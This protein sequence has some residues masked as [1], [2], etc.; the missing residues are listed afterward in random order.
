ML[1]MERILVLGI[2]GFLGNRFF[3]YPQTKYNLIGTSRRESSVDDS[4]VIFFEGADFSSLAKILD[5]IKPSIVLNF[6]AITNVDFC[7]Q[8]ADISNV[9]NNLLPSHLAIYTHE[10]GIKLIH[11]STDHFQSEANVPRTEFTNVWSV[12]SYGKSKLDAEVNILEK[13]KNAV[14]IRTNF[15]GLETSHI[16]KKLLSDIKTQLEDESN[17]FGFTDVIFSPVSI[18]TLIPIIYKLIEFDVKGVINISSNESIS[19]FHFAQLVAIGLYISPD[20]VKPKSISSHNLLS[21]RPSYLALDNSKVKQILNLELPSL[22]AMIA[23]ELKRY[24]H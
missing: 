21:K 23:N 22:H 20:K 15:F 17:F 2:D 11:L 7:E 1:L 24:V 3:H 4:R 10:M 8:H 5:K 9:I 16:N 19:K 14:I 18:D 13:D 6:I 12:N